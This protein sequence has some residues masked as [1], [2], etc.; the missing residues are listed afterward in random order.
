MSLVTPTGSAP[1]IDVS[2]SNI[3]L[4]SYGPSELMSFE[5]ANGIGSRDLGNNMG[6]SSESTSEITVTGSI[7]LKKSLS[8]EGGSVVISSDVT[9]TFFTLLLFFCLDRICFTGPGLGRFG[10][11]ENRDFIVEAFSSGEGLGWTISSGINFFTLLGL[12]LDSPLDLNLRGFLLFLCLSAKGN[13]IEDVEPA[14][15]ASSCARGLLGSCVTA[16]GETWSS[17]GF[18]LTAVN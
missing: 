17:S 13:T 6:E 10:K 8:S 16:L 14:A 3:A 2:L 18:P 4:W 11:P 5:M 15:V 9:M 7:V 12:N 1:V